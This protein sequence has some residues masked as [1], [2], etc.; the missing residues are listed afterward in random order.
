MLKR[1]LDSLAAQGW[2]DTSLPFEKTINFTQG[3]CLWLLLTRN[4]V[5][6]TY[7][8]FS[9]SISLATEAKRCAAAANCYPTLVP[10][11]VGYLHEDGLDVLACRA[12]EFRGLDSRRL[13]QAAL[14]DQVFAD[15]HRY[16]RAMP[17]TRLPSE[18]T[19]L[20]N[21]AVVDALMAYF[22]SHPQ[23]SLVRRWLDGDPARLA[24]SLPNMP[25]H[26]DLVLNNMGQ[27]HDG[28]ALLIDWEDFGASCLPGLD[29][30]TL[31]LSLAGNAT[32]LLA[33]RAR[34]SHPTQR[35]VLEACASLQIDIKDYLRLTPVY[36]LVFRY[37]KRN[38]GPGVRE[39]FDQ[40]LID[41]EQRESARQA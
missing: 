41:L 1:V 40:V 38:Y 32:A 39:R 27:T 7:V 6:D 10:G 9:D 36:A 2:F 30:F 15:L 12:V 25:Q 5:C 11:F 3:A 26:S 18:L 20:D 33:E 14:R 29:L 37:L 4:G 13:Q 22:D 17:T 35:F 23:R 19:P 24:Q 16:F 8:K 34:P 21:G 31:E 28:S